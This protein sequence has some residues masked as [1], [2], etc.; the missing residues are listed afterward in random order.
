MTTAQPQAGDD[1]A[2]FRTH[3]QRT[4]RLTADLL[5]IQSGEKNVKWRERPIVL[6]LAVSM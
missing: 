4:R 2:A 3:W 6:D 5:Q 1:L